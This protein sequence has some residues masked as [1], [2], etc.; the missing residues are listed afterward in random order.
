MSGDLPPDDWPGRAYSRI[1]PVA[2]HRWHVQSVGQGPD[3]LLL[4][5]AGA[6]THS[7]ARLAPILAQGAHVIMLDLPGHGYT[8]S[9]RGRARLSDVAP[10]IA[11]LCAAEG[12]QPR[13]VIG[14]SAGAA[15]AL[16]MARSG[17]VTPDR[18]VAINGALEDFKGPAGVLF[19]MMAKLL[20]LNPFS[21]FLTARGSNAEAQVR[22][23]IAGTGSEI[24][25]ASLA[26]YARLIGR[27]A[28]V[29]G[30]LAMMAQWSLTDLNR[31]LPRIE[32]PTL[33]LHGDRDA[34]VPLRV[35]ERAAGLMPNASLTVLQGLG[36]LAHEE[37]PE[38]IGRLID[39]VMEELTAQ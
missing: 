18:I 32:T 21:G 7:W 28:H 36:H 13:V 17:V 6:S 26:L 19:P 24:D 12:W 34:A 4:H 27:K 3:V 14:H 15:V 11:A 25:D 22:R 35:S 39:D 16:E 20:A 37:R 38:L 10:D 2:P 5:G 23:I 31:A 1:V 30:T 33:F 9:P 29:D 8:R